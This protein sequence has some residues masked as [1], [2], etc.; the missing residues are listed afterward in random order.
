MEFYTHALAAV[1]EP[2]LVDC[3]TRLAEME[4][5]HISVFQELLDL[6]YEKTKHDDPEDPAVCYLKAFARGHVFDRDSGGPAAMAGLRTPE[7]ILKK[8]I[9]AEKDSI[10]LYTGI[11]AF[12]ADDTCGREKIDRVLADEMNHL[13]ELSEC[14]ENL[15]GARV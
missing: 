1:Q 7:D 15:S 10:A 8:A 13:A 4:Q 14:L 9:V 2:E 12:I 11:K 5:E 6:C 3:F